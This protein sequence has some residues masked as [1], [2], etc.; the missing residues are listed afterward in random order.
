MTIIKELKKS[1]ANFNEDDGL[2]MSA[3]LSFYSAFSLAPLLLIAISIAGT[4]LGNDEVRTALDG[5][6]R[7]EIG[8]SGAFVIQEM[9]AHARHHSENLFMSISG[10]AMLLIGAAGVFE[11]LQTALNT[12]WKT[13]TAPVSGL[14][15]FVKTHLLSFS[16]VLVSGFLLLI[17]MILTTGLQAFNKHVGEA[18]GVPTELLALGGALLSFAVTAVLFASIFKILPNSP[19]GWKDVTMGAVVT[20]A[21]FMIGKMAIAWYLGREATASSY[22]SAGSFIVVLLWLYY[23]SIILLY[24]AEFTAVHACQ[25]E[26]RGHRFDE[27]S[28]PALQRS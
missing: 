23:S 3:A 12:I 24:G 16:M 6:L 19:V 21:L 26:A 18:F 13:S 7:D 22:G 28:D 1:F 2:R 15:A 27:K 25:R 17:S 10:L 11:Q 14:R 20:A 8:P 4:F 9:V 5:G